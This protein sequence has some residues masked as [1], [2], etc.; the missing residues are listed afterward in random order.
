MDNPYTRLIE[1]INKAEKRQI[2]PFRMGKVI[3]VSP[4]KVEVEGNICDNEIAGISSLYAPLLND[5][6]LLANIGNTDNDY[7]IICKVV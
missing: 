5:T 1:L 3:S 7:I 6:V 4:F 2:A